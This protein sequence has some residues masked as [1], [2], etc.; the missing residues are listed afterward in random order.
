MSLIDC[1]GEKDKHSERE[2]ERERQ[3]RTIEEGRRK[4]KGE[5]EK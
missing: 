3:G 2:R 4:T 5:T 1:G